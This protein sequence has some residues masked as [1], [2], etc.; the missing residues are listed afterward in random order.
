[1]ALAS[2]P[3]LCEC[4]KQCNS[5]RTAGCGTRAAHRPFSTG[6]SNRVRAQRQPAVARAGKGN[7]TGASLRDPEARF[8][9]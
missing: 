8:K 1:M 2:A 9:R 3:E 6:S 4:I 5:L 7:K